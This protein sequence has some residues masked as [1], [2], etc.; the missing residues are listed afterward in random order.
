[1]EAAIQVLLVDDEKAFLELGKR[2][3]EQT[4]EFAV[5]TAQSARAPLHS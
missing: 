1:M 2:Y 3:L 4:P 5:T